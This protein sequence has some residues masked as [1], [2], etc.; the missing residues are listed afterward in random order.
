MPVKAIGWLVGDGVR[1]QFDRV[2]DT[3][4]NAMS[5]RGL[6]PATGTVQSV[7]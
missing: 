5:S 4:L 7:Q 2:A 6:P 1:S 3:S